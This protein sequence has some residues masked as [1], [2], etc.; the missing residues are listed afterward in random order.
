M[1]MTKQTVNVHSFVLLE[2]QFSELNDKVSELIAT[3]ATDGYVT[4]DEVSGVTTVVRHWL[5]QAAA[6]AWQLWVTAY[7]A[8]FGYSYSSMTVENI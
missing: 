1:A 3:D 5:D 7:V 8:Q 4:R 2:S 6:D